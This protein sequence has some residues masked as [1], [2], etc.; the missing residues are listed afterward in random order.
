MRR[1][2][3]LDRDGVLNA[4][5]IDAR[6]GTHPPGAAAEVVVLPGVTKA[7]R[8]LKK[9]NFLLIVATNQPDV[10]RG[11]QR[12]E[13]VDEINDRLMGS[14]PLDEVVVC[15]HDDADGCDCRKPRP[16]LLLEAARRWNVSL[17]ESFMVGDRESDVETGLRAGCV[18]V[19]IA[20]PWEESSANYV[21]RSLRE[22]VEWILKRTSRKEEQ[23]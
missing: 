7:C 12:R 18:T 1:A 3:F 8:R 4:T 23:M 14:L 20:A 17:A 5:T 19:R 9:A 10:A 11:T 16:G 15:F 22:A 2:V 6:G 21:A 13:V